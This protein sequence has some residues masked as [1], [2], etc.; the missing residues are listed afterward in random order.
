M[1]KN[2][3]MIIAAVAIV[4]IVAVA[5]VLIVNP[6]GG[7][8]DDSDADDMRCLLRVYGNADMNNYLDNDDLAY[9]KDIVDEK[10]VWDPL[11]NPL[12][13]TNGDNQITMEDYNLV[14][15]YLDGKASTMYYMDWDNKRA[16]VDYP[17]GNQLTG[18]N[19]IVVVFT[20]GL[21]IFR[22]LGYYDK[23]TLMCNSDIAVSSID[24]ALYPGIDKIESYSVPRMTH[25]ADTYEMFVEKNIKVVLAEQRFLNETFLTAAEEDFDTHHVNVIKL[26]TNR[27]M[28]GITWEDTLVT[29]GVMFNK[30]DAT[31]AYIDTL[32][33]VEKEIE[34]A[35]NSAKVTEK[36]ILIPY[37]ADGYD[38]N[39][40]YIDSRG[41]S[42]IFTA[43]VY[44]T[45]MIPLKS[46]I[47]LKTA[48]GFGEVDVEQIIEKN[49]D[50]LVVAAFGYA[51]NKDFT[52]DQYESQVKEMCA[53]FRTLGYNKPIYVLPFESC[54]LAGPSFALVVSSLIWGNDAFNAD[55]AWSGFYDFFKKYMGFTGSL[56]D[57]KNSK[58]APW[59]YKN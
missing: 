16:S 50:V 26:P 47:D 18:D 25:T 23:V 59:E 5:A 55:S 53:Q 29:L 56:D 8:N 11:S 10:K 51:T 52:K 6:F 41:T 14:K 21:D 4:A 37:F 44:L 19:G 49:P 58:F 42:G 31:K 48:D 9:I 33:N 2:Q 45:E 22:T 7:N 24:P 30:Q 36:S 57:L 17:L 3:T 1:E 40:L 34:D 54:V 38:L 12:A 39:P 32:T 35:V 28:K 13:D 15:G 43:D 20:T 46:A 27:Y